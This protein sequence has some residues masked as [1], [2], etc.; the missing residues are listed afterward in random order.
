MGNRVRLSLA[1]ALLASTLLTPAPVAADPVSIIVGIASAA[2]AASPIATGLAAFSWGAFALNAALGLALTGLGALTQ[3]SAPSLSASMSGRT[4]NIRQPIS[5]RVTVYGR[6]KVGGTLIFVERTTTDDVDGDGNDEEEKY[7]HLVFAVAAHEIDAFEE[8]YIN[9]KKVNVDFDDGGRVT[10]SKYK[11]RVW[12]HVRHGTEDQTAFSSLVE[13]SD[14]KWTNSHR[15]RGC[16]LIYAKV[17]VTP[18]LLQGQ[19]PPNISAVIRGKKVKNIITDVTE[20]SDNAVFCLRDY[21]VTLGEKLSRFD[22]ASWLASAQIAREDVDKRDASKVKRYTCN[23]LVVADRTPQDIIRSQL[24]TIAGGIT[25]SGGKWHCKAGAWEAPIITFDEDDLRGPVKI[26]PRHSIN[27]NFNAVKGTFVGQETD[28]QPDTYPAITSNYFT[29]IDGG[30][31]RFREV[32]LPFTG[33]SDEA[34]RIAKIALYRSREQIT[35]QTTLG[36]RALSVMNGD[37]VRLNMSRFG[38]DGKTFEVTNWKFVHTDE[39]DMFVNVTLREISPEVFK[40]NAEEKSF[41]R[42]N[43][44]LP[45]PTDSPEPALMLDSELRTINEHVIAVLL[46]QVAGR[47]GRFGVNEVQY[48]PSGQSR[49]RSVG[50]QATRFFEVP[51]VKNGDLYDIRAR[52][53][54]VFGVP[55]EWTTREDYKISAF[56]TVPDPVTDF[57]VS[58]SDDVLHFTWSAVPDLDLS[59]YVIRW[60]PKTNGNATWRNSTRVG[61]KIPRP[62]TAATLEARDGTYMIK[63]VD[64]DGNVSPEPAQVIV[65]GTKL[66]NR[67]IIQT[68]VE[69]PEFT[70]ADN[71]DELEVIELP[72]GLAIAQAST[73][74]T[75]Y[76]DFSETV[77]L[78]DVYAV[79]VRAV[80]DIE[81]HEY[82][83]STFDSTPGLF[84]D[85]EGLFENEDT[86]DVNASVQVAYRNDTADPWS[87][88][89]RLRAGTYTARYFKFRAVLTSDVADLSPLVTELRVVIDVPDRV[90]SGTEI[91]SNT[92]GTDI[93]FEPPFR[94][95][96]GIAVAVDD[97]NSGDYYRITNRSRNGFT[98][99]FFNSGGSGISRTFDWV[100]RG[101]GRVAT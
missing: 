10:N 23:G 68:I 94:E 58:M 39:S 70:G 80:I 28:W 66:L 89:K 51:H 20:W 52:S 37:I 74:G 46:V 67:N 32:D 93:D 91:V 61:E 96:K 56:S 90:L 78:G 5:P 27:D 31:Q 60:S 19:F 75:V 11:D 63:A 40:W 95:L 81:R 55:S 88:W 17:W 38:F 79:N 29:N 33:T 45:D 87:E 100:A 86:S 83:A 14:G 97:M 44:N 49:W 65:D 72:A 69:H 48:R 1:A 7:L 25:W 12:I 13:E 3:P 21:L 43:T 15:C 26:L 82:G 24:T 98:I 35:V 99:R 42:N 6:Q 34:Q 41:E 22:D 8:F 62:A 64:K 50:R 76:Y 9:D 53:F 85:R 101:V 30:E 77:N 73:P 84:D 4:L 92:G 71:I 16:A 18:E 2:L 54:N 36:M 59:H 57:D 47:N